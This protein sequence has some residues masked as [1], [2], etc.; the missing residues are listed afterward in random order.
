MNLRKDSCNAISII[1]I[2][3]CICL[4]V[5]SC[6]YL[7][8][9]AMVKGEKWLDSKK[10]SPEIN[11]SGS[12]TSPEW[13]LATFKQENGTKDVTGMLGEYPVKGVVSGNKIYLFMYSG[14]S[15]HYFA[16]LNASDNNTMNGLYS[17]YGIIDD[18]AV[19]KDTARY[20]S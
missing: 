15:I 8:G 3:V 13:G 14:N 10:D 4:Y 11:I 12:W 5:L 18:D 20:S 19:R 2:V 6:G 7:N 1:L 9:V 17:K 16:E